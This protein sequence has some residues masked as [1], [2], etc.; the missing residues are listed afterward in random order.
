M[1][2]GVCSR[3]ERADGTGGTEMT[4]YHHGLCF[5]AITC[6]EGK[7]GGLMTIEGKTEGSGHT[8]GTFRRWEF[9]DRWDSGRFLGA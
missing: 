6:Q 1:K 8:K 2:R 4:R 7:E 3:M 9:W 5:T